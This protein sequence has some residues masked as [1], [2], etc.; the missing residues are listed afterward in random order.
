VVE[1]T[2]SARLIG[3]EYTPETEVSGK[4]KGEVDFSCVLPGANGL[5]TPPAGDEFCGPFFE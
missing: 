1:G 5:E 2:F 4:F 3:S